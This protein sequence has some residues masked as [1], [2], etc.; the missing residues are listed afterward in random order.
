ME[1]E[2]QKCLRGGPQVPLLG[3]TVPQLFGAHLLSV[4]FWVECWLCQCNWAMVISAII[5]ATDHLVVFGLVLTGKP[6]GLRVGLSTGMGAG[7]AQD[8]QGLPVPFPMHQKYM[9]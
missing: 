5:A 7:I 4:S 9:N 8:T 2:T 1:K 3:P 6:A